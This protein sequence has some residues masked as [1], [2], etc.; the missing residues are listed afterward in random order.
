MFILWVTC[1]WERMCYPDVLC[2]QLFENSSCPGFH[3][4][5]G[6]SLKSF[7]ALEVGQLQ[8]DWVYDWEISF[9]PFCILVKWSGPWRSTRVWPKL[10]LI[11]V[12]V[13][14]LFMI[15]PRWWVRCHRLV[16]CYATVWGCC[17]DLHQDIK[18]F[19]LVWVGLQLSHWSEEDYSPPIGRRRSTALPLV[20]GVQTCK[21]SVYTYDYY[22][23][24]DTLLT[25]RSW[26]PVCGSSPV[27]TLCRWCTTTNMEL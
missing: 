26:K 8:S 24:I 27:L 14:E 4:A 6:D 18:A 19:L 3:G 5:D 22:I 16:V 20:W 23:Y 7:W 2:K 1:L 17:G 13:S 11:H 9:F 21:V 10:E 25:V 15:V 12:L